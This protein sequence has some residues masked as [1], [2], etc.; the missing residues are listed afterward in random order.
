MRLRF[1]FALV[2]STLVAVLGA[3]GAAPAQSSAKEQLGPP[4]VPG[5]LIVRYAAGVGE[6]KRDAVLAEVG[7]RERRDFGRLGAE[8]VSVD[9]AETAQALATLNDD[10][11]VVYAEPNYLLQADGIPNDGSFRELWGLHNTGQTVAGVAGTSDADIDAVE[12]W[13]VATGS[14]AT[15]VAVI[16]TGID[17]THPDLGGSA[18][19]SPRMWTNPGESCAGCRTDGIDN[20]AD[21][22]VDDWRGWDFANRDSSAADDHGHGTHVAGTIGAIGDDG[23]GVTGISRSGVRL[24]ALKF[25]DAQGVGTTADGISAILYA[26]S[27]GA[28]VINASWGGEGYSQATVDAIAEADRQGTLFVAAAGNDSRDNDSQPHYPSSYDVPNIVAVAATDASDGLATFSNFGREGVD[29]GAPGDHIYSTLPGGTYDWWSGTSMATPHVAGAAAL[30]RS[31]FPA[32]TDLATKALL[33]RTVDERASLS[34][35]ATKGRLNLDRAVRCSGG[36][37]AWIESPRPGFTVSIGEPVAI[38]AIGATC[39]SP[40]PMTMSAN[41]EAVTLTPRGDGLYTGTYVPRAV[42]PLSLVATAGTDTQTAVGSVADNYRFEDGPYSW[43]DATAGGT[44][45]TLGDDASATVALPFAFRFFGGSFSSLRVSSNGYLVLGPSATTN[46]RNVSIPNWTEPNGFIAPHWD[47]LNPTRAGAVWYRTVGTTPARKFVVAWVG[48][49]HFAEIAPGTITFEA[50][51]EEG[52]NDIAFQYADLDIGHEFYDYGGSATV[53]VENADGTVGREYLYGPDNARLRPYVG[54]KSLRFLYGDATPRHRRHHRHRHRHRHRLLLRLLLLLLLLLLCR[55]RSTR[56]RRRRRSRRAPRARR[57]PGA[58]RSSS[59]RTSRDRLSGARSTAWRSRPAPRRGRT[60]AC[61][62]R[63]TRSASGRPTRPATWT[64]LR[65]HGPGA[66]VATS[67]AARRCM[68][69]Q[70]GARDRRSAYALGRGRPLGT[71]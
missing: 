44:R 17:F 46:E 2:G 20:D 67:R 36:G 18:T 60:P 16:D 69:T 25:L 1:G 37:K 68:R 3:G 29:L 56:R 38:R 51:L 31:V 66:S 64:R 61:R 27:H 63:P 33:L 12:A 59:S 53:G 7:A 34:W 14:S 8:L 57:R 52:T 26:A 55:R 4:A 30:L 15:V 54:A 32:A 42:G 62:S 50:V 23:A 22:Y 65:P 39:A 19:A 24:M 9:A 5:E 49:A 35:L 21:G 71:G 47:D 58:R 13:D 70:P 48:I 6:A 45:L 43:I 41:G 10:P 28:H 11:R 40:G